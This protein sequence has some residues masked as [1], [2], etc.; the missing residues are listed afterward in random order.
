[1]VILHEFADKMCGTIKNA[2]G[3]HLSQLF[4][5]NVY[6]NKIRL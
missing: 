3:T 1:M 5:L 2:S 4:L 6:K